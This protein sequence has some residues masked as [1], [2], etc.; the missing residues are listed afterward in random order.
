MQSEIRCNIRRMITLKRL[1]T[2][3][4]RTKAG[5]STQK[6]LNVA[7]VL[8][9]VHTSAFPFDIMKSRLPLLAS[10]LFALG[11]RIFFS[12]FNNE[13]GHRY[14]RGTCLRYW[15]LC[16]GYQRAFINLVRLS[17]WY[18]RENPKQPLQKSGPFFIK[19][20]FLS[21]K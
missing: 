8:S 19:T 2:T 9:A 18:F 17:R 15:R 7:I 11:Q 3:P 13:M 12:R 5:R 20:N 1:H 16:C 4:Y 10:L 21:P 14:T 6:F